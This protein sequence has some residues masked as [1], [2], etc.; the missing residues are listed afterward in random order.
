MN[1]WY[2]PA[3]ALECSVVR[4]TFKRSI[5]YASVSFELEPGSLMS[6]SGGY[7]VALLHADGSA[8]VL[9]DEGMEIPIR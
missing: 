6:H 3:K 9:N 7:S 4:L 5:L 2:C 8:L 1:E